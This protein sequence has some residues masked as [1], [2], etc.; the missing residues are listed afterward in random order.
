MLF[1][2]TV[3]GALCSVALVLNEHR[4]LSLDETAVGEG[5]RNL[6]VVV[7]SPSAQEVSG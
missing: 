3:L 1:A 4:Q 7:R 6:G 2:C 5:A